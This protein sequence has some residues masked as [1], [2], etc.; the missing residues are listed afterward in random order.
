MLS[1]GDLRTRVPPE[2]DPGDELGVLSQAFNRMT[3]RRIESQRNEARREPIS[4]RRGAAPVH[5]GACLLASPPRGVI[6]LD[7]A[8]LR[9]PAEQRLAQASTTATDHRRRGSASTDR[10]PSCRRWHLASSRRRASA[11]PGLRGEF[12]GQASSAAAETRTTSW[13]A[14]SAEQFMATRLIGFRRHDSDDVT[15][16]PSAQRK[17]AWADVSAAHRAQRSRARSLPSSSR[18]SG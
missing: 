8:G 16:L 15:E 14:S 17:A 9:Q 5:R 4:R 7:E 13:S 2:G 11:R 10:L 18:P 1:S 3:R 6:G 12:G